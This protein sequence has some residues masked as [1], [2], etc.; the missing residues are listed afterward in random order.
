ME[1]LPTIEISS[2]FGG[3]VVLCHESEPCEEPGVILTAEVPR[4]FQS[5]DGVAD[6]VRG[7]L[8]GLEAPQTEDS[9]SNDVERALH[10]KKG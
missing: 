7:Y 8:R 1:L 6:F 2:I 10:K 3:Y 5:A 4:S 9:P